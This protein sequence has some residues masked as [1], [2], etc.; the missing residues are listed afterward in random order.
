MARSTS[1][2]GIFAVGAAV[3]AGCL[4]PIV[5]PSQRS[6]S[7]S[8][9]ATPAAIAS[10]TAD[11][12]PAPTPSDAAIGTSAGTIIARFHLAVTAVA[13]DRADAWYVRDAGPAGR[14]GHVTIDGARLDEVA[15]GPVPVA[16]AVGPDALYV[17]EG[18]PDDTPRRGL[19]RT[20]VLER[21]DPTTM[22]VL[23]SAPIPGLPVDVEIDG[24]RVWVGGV[25]GWVGS[26][27]ATTLE[28]RTAARLTGQGSSMVGIG[29]GSVWVVNGVAEQHAYLVHRLDPESG[30]EQSTW[31]VPGD[32][33]LGNVAV[34][35]RVW[36]AGWRDEDYLLTPI[37]P[38]GQVEPPLKVRPVAALRAAAGSL[39]VLPTAPA[40]LVRYDEATLARTQPLGVGDVGQDLALSA[41]TVW[42]ASEDLVAVSAAP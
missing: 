17:L 27:D 24:D 33:V 9:S 29:A 40:G 16:V 30:R 39:W 41:T 10:A 19:P 2:L 5:P 15:A 11:G 28:R 8:P 23:A 37:T 26:F 6:S 1:L 4:A 25:T 13:A 14:V 20:G 21:L 3:V 36:V 42:T 34:G 7:S 31:T 18:V 22:R 35:S 32:G 38:D 12:S